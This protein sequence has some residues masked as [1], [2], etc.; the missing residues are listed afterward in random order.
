VFLK[1]DETFYL[2]QMLSDER[3][4]YMLIKPKNSGKL[5]VRRKY[6]IVALFSIHDIEDIKNNKLTAADFQFREWVYIKHR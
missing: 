2:I 3:N 6:P 4:K 1:D 5:L